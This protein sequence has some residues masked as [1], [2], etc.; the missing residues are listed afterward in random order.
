MASYQF[1]LESGFRFSKTISRLN[2]E[3]MHSISRYLNIVVGKGCKNLRTFF[4][5]LKVRMKAMPLAP[6]PRIPP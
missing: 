6:L 5:E 1:C 4:P 3:R 2:L